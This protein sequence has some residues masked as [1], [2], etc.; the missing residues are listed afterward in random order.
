[1]HELQPVLVQCPYCWEN[2][3]T[4]VDPSVATQEYVEDCQICC[5]PIVLA[6]A[7]DAGGEVAIEV[8]PEND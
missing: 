2:F 6:V 3:E 5:N 7:L 4:L 8:R 1:M